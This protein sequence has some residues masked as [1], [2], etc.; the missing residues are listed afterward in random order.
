MARHPADARRRSARA[1]PCVPETTHR[2]AHPDGG[3]R[4]AVISSAVALALAA[5]TRDAPTGPTP[6]A[7]AAVQA[8]S[9]EMAAT[10]PD[11]AGVGEAL[12]D[13]TTRLAPTVADAV[14]RAQLD[15]YLQ[16]LSAHL[17]AGK[18]DQALRV[19]ALARKALA[20]RSEAGE[21]ADLT[22][23]GLAL[24]QVE[25]L[26]KQPGAVQ[27]QPGAEPTQP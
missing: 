20:A 23:I 24:D 21:Q 12:A 15:G 11:R 9:Q 5:C 13:A 6:S 16:D 1:A 10:A 4:R 19:L 17:A 25:A 26:L 3:A 18:T 14:A 22:M 2:S 27:L 8:A 7:A